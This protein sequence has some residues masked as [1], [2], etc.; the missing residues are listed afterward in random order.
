MTT[1]RVRKPRASRELVSVGTHVP[2]KAKMALEAYAASMKTTVYA[3]LQDW[4]VEATKDI[5]V[6]VNIP[7]FDDYQDQDSNGADLL[8]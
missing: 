4:I 7:Q 3:L 1:M 5:E 2:L 8:G 6:Q